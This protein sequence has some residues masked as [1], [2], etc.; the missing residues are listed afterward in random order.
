MDIWVK[1][2]KANYAKLVKAFNHF[3]LAIFDMTEEKFLNTT[4]NDV[5]TFGRQPVS[6]DIMTKVNG[7]DFENTLLGSVEFEVGRNIRVR[8]IGLSD[9]IN[10]KNASG[11]HKDLDDIEHLTKGEEQSPLTKQL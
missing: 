7:L 9:L 11:R 4:E 8:T 1:P 2:T 5:F 10:A 6:I 3:G